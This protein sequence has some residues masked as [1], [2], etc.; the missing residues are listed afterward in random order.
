MKEEEEKE[1]QEHQELL[2]MAQT[3][4]V[5]PKGKLRFI[6]ILIQKKQQKLQVISPNVEE[7]AA[8][9]KPANNSKNLK[10]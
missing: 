5:A 6:D 8:K 10:K 3:I 2:E 4:P 1:R 9:K 7:E